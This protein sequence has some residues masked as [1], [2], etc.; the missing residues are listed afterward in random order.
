MRSAT[1]IV[2]FLTINRVIN[3]LICPALVMIYEPR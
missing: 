1:Y 2:E 3:R